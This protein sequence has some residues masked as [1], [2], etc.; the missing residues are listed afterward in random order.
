MFAMLMNINSQIGRVKNTLQHIHYR[1]NKN[2]V[3]Q[4]KMKIKQKRISV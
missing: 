4:K 1:R 2:I 3:Q